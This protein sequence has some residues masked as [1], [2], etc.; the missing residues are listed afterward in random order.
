MNMTV[1]ESRGRSPRS[2]FDDPFLNLS[3]GRPITV[4]GDPLPLNVRP[5]P[6]RNRPADFIG[7]VGRFKITS[8]LEPSTIKAGESVTLTIQIKGTGKIKLIPDLEIPPLTD[9]KIYADQPVLTATQDRDGLGGS[10]TMKWAL[11]PEKEGS[12]TIPSISLTYFDVNTHQYRTLTTPPHSLTVLPGQGQS[13]MNISGTLKDEGTNE[14]TKKTIKE[15]GR[16][17]LPIH[18]SVKALSQPLFPERNDPAIGLVVLVPVFIYGVIFF[19][20]LFKKKSIESQAMLTAKR[21]A[22]EFIKQYNQKDI[23][24]NDLLSVIRDYLNQRL[25]LSLGALTTDEASE[26]LKS[27]GVSHEAIQ[28]MCSILQKCEDAVYTGRGRTTLV[29]DVDMAKLIKRIDK[30]IR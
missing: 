9:T 4:T 16:D 25:G 6:E 11:V 15:L 17:I 12:I 21:A 30:E 2:L 19:M 5:L 28:D 7:L 14:S 27:N 22:K 10:K 8:S 24:A 29:Q 23:C 1:L 13:N 18:T 20:V 26:I 3:T